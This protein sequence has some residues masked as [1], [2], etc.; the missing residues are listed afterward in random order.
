VP[1]G[2]LPLGAAC[3]RDDQCQTR[4]CVR[5]A[6]L[7]PG[8]A[9]PCRRDSECASLGVT[10][11]CALD[12]APTGGRWAC[13]EVT[14]AGEDSGN[15]CRA[16]NDCFSNLCYEG[17]CRNPCVDGGECTAG[18]RCVPTPP[19]VGGGTSCGT[20]AVSGVYVD[21]F[22]LT[23]ESTMAGRGTTEARL[24]VPN[25]AVSVMWTTLDMEGS[26]VFTAVGAVRSPSNEALVN[27]NTWSVVQDQP[28][29]TLPARFQFNSALLPSSNLLRVMPGAYRSVHVFLNPPGVSVPARRLRASAIIKRAPG[30]VLGTTWRLRVGVWLVGIPGLSAAS[31][32]S[33]ARLQAALNR[34]RQIYAAANVG[35]EVVGY[36]DFPAAQAARYAVID[37]RAELQELFAQTGRA[38]GPVLNLMLV[39]GISGSA[40]LEN[41]IGIAGAIA[42]PAGL[43]GT[44]ASGVVAGWESTLGRTDLLPQ[45]IAHECGHYLGL[46]HTR[47]SQA[48]C[49]TP[50]QTMCSPFGGVDPITDTPTDASAANYLM[51]WQASNG[52]NVTL[53]PGQSIVMRAHPLVQ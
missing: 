37:S 14:G 39:R 24:L 34:M 50:A 40:G 25:D 27:L 52:S 3:E 42:G 22:T 31:A 9:L 45:T 33:N 4:V 49:A 13:G 23:E 19:T 20:A 36:Q 8:C 46:W 41:A 35:L 32:P 15:A 10:F 2:D 17:R 16:D 43:H 5:S 6:G 44:I 38:T 12:R 7:T 53:S 48:P 51:Y 30:A 26:N 11:A 18:W 47:E 29:R 28:I 21:A 1:G